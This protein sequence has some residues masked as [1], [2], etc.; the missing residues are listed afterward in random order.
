MVRIAIANGE[1]QMG[2]SPS[3]SLLSARDQIVEKARNVVQ[4]YAAARAASK[5]RSNPY[6]SLSALLQQMQREYEDRFLYELIQNAYDA[7][8]PGADGQ[9]AVLLDELE[10]EHGV[11][12]VANGGDPFG[13]DD[14]EAICELAQSNKAVDQSIGNKGV[15]FKSV[16]QVSTW[17]E[18]YSRA[19]VGSA[20]FDGFCFEFARPVHYQE[21][22]D[23]DQDLTEALRTDV[24]PYFLPVPI[25]EIPV[26]VGRFADEGFAS[27]IRLPLDSA[28]ALAIVKDRLDRLTSDT[29]PLHLFL[30]RLRRLAIGCQSRETASEVILDRDARA[31]DDPRDDPNQR[32]EFVDL[33]DQGEW[34]VSHRRLTAAEMSA[35]IEASI[36]AK[37]L[38]AAWSEWSEDAWVSVAV[39]RDGHSIEPRMYTYLP[40]E[41]GA[42]A[43][44][45]GHL[46]APFSTKLARTA[47]SESVA[48]N[49]RLLDEA[50]RA[51]TAAVL[52]FAANE[53][54][55]PP[56]ALVD[57][58]AWDERHHDR[59]TESFAEKD[60]DMKS[61]EVV[62]IHRLPD[63]RTR[64]GFDATFTWLYETD[65]LGPD[66]I[67]RDAEAELVDS[68]I[69]GDRLDRLERYCQAFFGGGFT[70]ST[71]SRA[72]WVASAAAAML[73]RKAGFR[74]WDRFYGDLAVLFQDDPDALRGQL[75]LLGDDNELHAPPADSQDLDQPLVFFPP[76]RDRSDDDEAVEGDFDLTPPARLRRRLVLLNEK[77]RWNRQDGRIRR[78]TPARRFLQDN[79]LVRR[80]DTIDLLEHTERALA[81]S[82]STTLAREALS[83]AFRL[84][85]SARSIREDDLRRVNLRVPCEGKWIAASQAFFSAS[86][87]T[88]L[89]AELAELIDR[90]GPASDELADV[91]RRLV[92]PPDQRPFSLA[93]LARWRKFLAA[94]GVRDGL[95]PQPVSHSTDACEGRELRNPGSLI[96]RFGLSA[97]E[98]ERWVA[99]VEAGSQG[100]AR[101]PFTSYRPT[102]PIT[103]LPGQRDYAS[104]DDRT[105]SVWARL[106][107][108]GLEQWG[109]TDLDVVWSRYLARH[110]NDRDP[111]RWPSPVAAF[112]A[113]T[114]WLPITEPGERRDEVFVRPREAWFYSETTGDRPPQFSPLVS[115]RI[116]RRLS[117]TGVALAAMKGLGLGDW[118]DPQHCPALLGHLASLLEGGDLPE[119]GQWPLRNAL[120]E[121]WSRATTWDPAEFTEAMAGT[122][123][124]VT[125]AGIF[126][127]LQPADL[128]GGDL[129]IVPTGRSFAARV[130]EATGLP[131]LTVNEADTEA[132][133]S[134]LAGLVGEQV[135]T[136]DGLTVEFI[137]DG[138]PFAPDGAA[139]KLVD[140][141]Y[142]WL[143]KLIQLVL[144]AKRSHFDTSSARRRKEVLDTLR[145]V[146]VGHADEVQIKVG[147][148]TVTP[149]GPH[150]DVVPIDDPSN[151]TLILLVEGGDD[152]AEL[153]EIVPGLCELL[154]I[155]PYEDVIGRSLEKLIA[156]GV[157]TPTPA[158]FAQALHLDMARVGEVLSHLGEP[159]DAL[160]ILIAPAIACLAN[161]AAALALLEKR[162]AIDDDTALADVLKVVAG[163]TDVDVNK[164]IAE[165]RV[166]GSL[167][168]L[169]RGL[170]IDFAQFNAALRELGGEYT[171]LRNDAAHAHAVRYYAEVHR[172][173]LL[174]ALR[175][176]FLRVFR[177]GRSLDEYVAHRDLREL[178]PDPAWLEEYDVPPDELIEKHAARWIESVG[179][180]PPAGGDSL[181]PL[182]KLRPANREFVASTVALAVRCALAW[183]RKHDTAAPEALRTE[184]AVGNLLDQAVESGVLDF[185]PLDQRAVIGLLVRGGNWPEE[186]PLSLNLSDLG[187]DTTDL[188]QEQ[189]AEKLER[190]ERLEQRRH[191]S[192]DGQSFSAERDGYGLLANHVRSTIRPD[193]LT[194]GRRV[195]RLGLM[196]ERTPAKRERARG[197]KGRV[198]R[199]PAL[200]DHQTKAIGLVG[201]TIAY[202]W[203][204]HRYP[205]V[206]TPASWKSSYSESIGQP[207]GDDTLGY[208]FEIALKTITLFF[209]VKATSGTDAAFELGESEV[210]KARDCTR[211]DRFDFRIV[212]ITDVLDADRRQLFLLP[213]PMDPA[214]RDYFRFPGSGLTCAFR[215]E[216]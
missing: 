203:L 51:A 99:A 89:A 32:Y 144:E 64:G 165:A 126:E 200:S 106:V 125:R 193:L 85:A 8:P 57:L 122:P 128:D 146:R 84:F 163:G 129:Y 66:L 69:E 61:A 130:L 14:F 16:L 107:A 30:P 47:V 134:L 166:A 92:D 101:Y 59:V 185:E 77:L 124:V 187:L 72:E 172:E 209:E 204:Q 49:A 83:F 37:D 74:M 136:A 20:T 76:A 175:H 100:A 197:A 147:E 13:A 184:D 150:R 31:I 95:W 50:A 38:D 12:Y 155:T 40:M 6:S 45:H 65:L 170:G 1:R 194:S 191:I 7:H 189:D 28:A 178:S 115:T 22:C 24:A 103:V 112:L 162:G 206:C 2:E 108:A 86:W 153:V 214:N 4:I 73:K 201:E 63:G 127:T 97:A 148:L 98:A 80:F 215:L 169:R 9:I 10:G 208:D 34:F 198:V 21:L 121:A 213:N 67:S 188:Q 182:S 118:L 27:V 211:S 78:A 3:V 17:P 142:E 33:G 151:P 212:F 195:A 19:D 132:V 105:R 58:L 62:P 161:H 25:D 36:E 145:R 202:E 177:E 186:M 60:I 143:P 117:D 140:A 133:A 71:E 46:H 119:S 183:T 160:I 135:K 168:D 123:L 167:D 102:R 210:G 44:L 199:A 52:T 116:R 158:D 207:A 75:V 196:P 120:L 179:E 88:E 113:D 114:E 26:A 157:E 111:I 90:A 139:A 93:N 96:R 56:T 39:R 190:Q 154:G 156:V 53:E 11:L 180:T 104:F 174:L 131:L 192:V 82:S 94:I 18:I 41:G 55:L 54:V 110:R 68:A 173:E 152:L 23:G 138:E 91:A 48:L 137:V 29:V 81:S 109:R 5:G 149:S 42:E 164:L 70:P 43:P 216:A 35:A 205:D 87:N 141:P 171:P 159:I 176:R 15:G 181:L 79:R